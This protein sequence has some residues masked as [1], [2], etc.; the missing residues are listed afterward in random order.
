MRSNDVS[1]W[2][3]GLAGDLHG[4]DDERP[5]LVLL[6]GL[7]FDRRM[8]QPTLEQ[9]RRL[10][11]GRR[12]LNLDLPGHGESR[13]R[14]S[15]RSDRVVTAIYDAVQDAGLHSPVLVGQSLA[16][17]L[18]TSYA[19]RYR[20]GGVVNVDRSLQAA[21]F[22]GMLQANETTLRGPDYLTLWNTMVASWHSELLPPQAQELVRLTS[23]P[24]QDLLLGYWEEMLTTAPDEIN[25]R[26][27]AD[28]V[29][30]RDAGVPYR[31]VFGHIPSVEHQTWLADIFPGATTTVLPDSGHFPQLAHPA[32]FAQMLADTGRIRAKGK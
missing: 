29:T 7:T 22:A 9:L 21:S 11:P 23:D 3:A 13:R 18:A 2:F 32:E 24:R 1:P 28:L 8:W 17:V 14:D 5:P 12:V 6:H 16:A 20:T 15:Y 26:V 30:L 27:V 19:T 10:D 4:E 25:D 31:I